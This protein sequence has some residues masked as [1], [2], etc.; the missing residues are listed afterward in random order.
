M[1]EAGESKEQLDAMGQR[2]SDA[3][4]GGILLASMAR[5]G[6]RY[7]VP[8]PLCRGC[9]LRYVRNPTGVCQVC[10]GRA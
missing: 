6:G 10:Q 1:A 4:V 9:G 3:V 7:H 2:Q 5:G 8:A